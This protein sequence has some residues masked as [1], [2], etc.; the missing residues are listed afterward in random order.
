MMINRCAVEFTVNNQPTPAVRWDLFPQPSDPGSG[1]SKPKARENAQR[2]DK[3]SDVV[4]PMPPTG[5]GRQDSG[6]KN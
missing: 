5:N 1:P 6:S 3:S 4:D 2:P